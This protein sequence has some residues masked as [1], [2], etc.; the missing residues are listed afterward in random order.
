MAGFVTSDE[1]WLRNIIIITRA[2]ILEE[3]CICKAPTVYMK[4][5]A[6]PIL[7]TRMSC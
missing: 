4:D 2:V 5:C 1:C 6:F 7:Q 3:V